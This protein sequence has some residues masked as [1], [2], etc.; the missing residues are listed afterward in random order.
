MKLRY[1]SYYNHIFSTTTFIAVARWGTVPQRFKAP[2]DCPP[3]RYCVKMIQKFKYN[4]I[5]FARICLVE[6]K[7]RVIM[8]LCVRQSNI[9]I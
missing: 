3:A 2:G 4:D 9:Y 8:R 5:M 1:I 6:Y 7:D